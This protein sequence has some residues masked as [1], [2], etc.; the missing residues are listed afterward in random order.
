MGII[1]EFVQHY[2]KEYDFYEMVSKLVAQQI[3]MSA[4]GL[5]ES[6]L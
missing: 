2:K 3:S 1:E 4:M 5:M 6:N